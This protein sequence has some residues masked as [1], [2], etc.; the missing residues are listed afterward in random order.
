ML[1][2]LFYH[3]AGQPPSNTDRGFNLGVVTLYLK[4]H[5]DTHCPDIKD[6]IEWLIPIQHETTDDELVA[7]CNTEKIDLLCSSHYIW[8]HRQLLGQLERIYPRLTNTKIVA[9]G[10]SI[11][12]NI[13]TSFFKKYPFIDYAVYGAGEHAFASLLQS[14]I[15]NRKLNVSDTSNLAWQDQGHQVV[16]EFKYVPQTAISPYTSNRQLFSKMIEQETQNGIFLNDITIPYE[17]TRGCPYSCTFCDWNSGLSNKVT[18]RKNTY[19]E[20]I[21][22][23]YDLGLR[24]IYLADANVGQYEED[25]ELVE[26]FAKKNLENNGNFYLEGNFSK[27]RKENNLKIYHT[28]GRAGLA[29][30]FIISVQD[31]NLSVLKNIDRPDVGWH[32]HEKIINELAENYPDIPAWVQVI[33]GLPGQTVETWRNSLA[34]I[35]KSQV[36]LM[37]FINELLPASP[38]A[39]DSTYQERFKFVYSNSIRLSGG[40]FYQGIFPESCVS[41]TKRDFVKMNMITII[42]NT[43]LTMRF[44]KNNI[45]VEALADKLLQTNEVQILEE[46]L[47]DNWHNHNNFFF[48][49]TFAPGMPET[50]PWSACDHVVEIRYSLVNNSHF[51]NLLEINL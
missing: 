46:N 42:Y 32:E 22:F 5:I 45:D 13:D 18:R 33:Q 26:Y 24:H 8:N 9:G 47:Y 31:T 36:E 17:L 12:V 41:F 40:N 28:M 35:A 48:T 39:R 7:I 37:P 34:L 29:R 2:L 20:E 10:P 3:A 51:L 49:K 15:H 50:T 44:T 38:A 30:R 11:D 23:F 21:D 16:S 4:T 6:Q 25:I 19:Q 43:L 14:V 27:L 1:K